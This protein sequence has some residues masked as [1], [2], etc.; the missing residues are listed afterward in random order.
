MPSMVKSPFHLRRRWTWI[1]GSIAAVILI[2]ATLSYFISSEALRRYME[3]RMNR[4]LKEYTVHVGRAYF[5]PIDFSLDLED[6]TLIQNANPDPPLALTG[7]C[8]RASTGGNS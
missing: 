4:Q 2:I 8:M 7:D 3:Q 6:L 1:L 5:H